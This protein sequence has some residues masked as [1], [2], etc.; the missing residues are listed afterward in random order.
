MYRQLQDFES[1]QLVSDM[2]GENTYA[3]KWFHQILASPD[4]GYFH[5]TL[6]ETSFQNPAHKSRPL[7]KSNNEW[8]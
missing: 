2:V 1:K 6:F 4:F 5:Y 3:V 8:V 7:V